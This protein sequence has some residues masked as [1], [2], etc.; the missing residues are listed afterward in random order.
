MAKKKQRAVM[1]AEHE[2]QRGTINDNHL[3]ALVTSQLFQVRVEKS[4]KGK[5]SFQR[6]P[7]HRKGWECGQQPMTVVVC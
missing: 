4:G 2:H 5:G 7:K 1:T 3:K 6:T